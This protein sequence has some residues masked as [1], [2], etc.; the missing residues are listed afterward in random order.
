MRRLS[1]ASFLVTPWQPVPGVV[2]AHRGPGR[3]GLTEGIVLVQR[4]L[5]PV[6]AG[7][8]A[9]AERTAK[10]GGA[11]GNGRFGE[12]GR[13]IPAGHPRGSAPG[14]ASTTAAVWKPPTRRAAATSRANRC[15]NS[16]SFA[17]RGRTTLIA[18][19]RPPGGHSEP[20]AG[21]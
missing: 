21:R 5:A 3:A 6:L 8:A 2:L 16:G 20:P 19:L 7:C 15:R 11:E 18:T 12:T 14:S 1:H 13:V 4:E 17:Y 10:A 9:G